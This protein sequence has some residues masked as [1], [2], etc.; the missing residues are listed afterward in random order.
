MQPEE[1]DWMP[2]FVSLLGVQ[3]A[4]PDYKAPLPKAFADDVVQRVGTAWRQE[5]GSYIINLTAFPVSNQ[6]L[7]RRPRPEESPDDT[8][9]EEQ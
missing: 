9:K 5:D 8:T 7:I 2:A 1:T 3:A 4:H 6:L